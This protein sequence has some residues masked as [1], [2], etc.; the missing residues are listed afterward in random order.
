MKKI[1]VVGSFLLMFVNV[2]AQD[3]LGKA[4]YF[5]K[6]IPTQ[7][8]QKTQTKDNE[9]IDP[10]FEKA[11]Q[12]AV[13]RASEKKFLLTFNKTECLYEEQ[14]ELEKP[15]NTGDFSITV[16]YSNAGKKYINTKE[17][18]SVVEDE[19]FGKEF[20]IVE[21]LVQPEWKL[22]NE[23]KK[24]GDYNCFKAELIIPVSKKQLEAYEEFL[25][26]EE[27]KPALFKMDKPEDRVIT[28]WYTPEIPVS[29]G[30]DNYWGL[31]GLILEVN[32][33]QYIILCSKVTLS[34]KDKTKIKAPNSGEKVNQ[35]KFDE[36]YKKKSDSMKNEDGVIIFAH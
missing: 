16:S 15:Q 17:K 30:P 33:G 28:V 19:I 23:S 14:K 25:K 13:K 3:F 18:N 22:I 1:I 12:D 29:F 20:L 32:D 27:T 21:P 36:I 10:E 24:I 5:S 35:K 8:V 31:P 7:K 4:E 6:K 11:L 34:N 26:N 2:N 9:P